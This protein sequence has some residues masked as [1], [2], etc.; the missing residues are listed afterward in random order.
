MRLALLHLWTALSMVGCSIREESPNGT[1]EIP[2]KTVELNGTLSYSEARR[3]TL[4][5]EINVF[6]HCMGTTETVMRSVPRPRLAV[7]D[8]RLFKE[9]DVIEARRVRILKIGPHGIEVEP[10]EG[11][12]EQH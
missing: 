8:G 7:I 12:D 5:C 9:G 11:R 3:V 2:R 1:S 10:I 4:D 6:G